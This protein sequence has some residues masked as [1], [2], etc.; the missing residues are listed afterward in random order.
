MGVVLA[1]L[2]ILGGPWPAPSLGADPRPEPAKIDSFTLPDQFG[3]LHSIAFPR[4]RPLVLLVGDRR[5]SEEI[6][7]WIEPLKQRCKD[8]ADIYGIADVQAVPRFLRG[9]VTEGIRKSRPKPLLL[10]FEGKVTGGL[11][12]EKKAANVF[13]ISQ[14]G[15]LLARV[16]GPFPSGTNTDPK[17]DRIVRAL[18]SSAAVATP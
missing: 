4:P 5:G 18:S 13:A 15:R 11:P 10:D 6:D 9:R 1:C 16:S 2:A 3:A 17:L 8:I 12:C 14:E 7:G